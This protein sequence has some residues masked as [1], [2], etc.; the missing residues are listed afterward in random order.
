M[1]VTK[2]FLWAVVLILVG[3]ASYFML[4]QSNST[5]EEDERNMAVKD[6]AN[7][8]RIFLAD[9][10]NNKVLLERMP[11]GHW[12]VDKKYRVRKDAVD[13]LLETLARITVKAPVSK[14]IYD[15]VLKNLAADGI[16]VEVY[17]SSS[18]KP[19]RVLYVGTANQEHSGTYMMLEGASKPFMMHIEGFY[20]FLTPRFIMKSSLWR[21]NG[22]FNYAFGEIESLEVNFVGE[23]ES[24][25]KILAQDSTEYQ[26]FDLKGTKVES[27]NKTNLYSYISLFS[28]INFEHIEDIRPQTYI[29]SVIATDPKIIYKVKDVFG[30]TKTVKTYTK[31][32]PEGTEDFDGNILEFDGDRLFILIDDETFAVAQYNTFDKIALKLRFFKGE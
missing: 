28:N 24:G 5:L 7:V 27:Y 3:A 14:S 25:F 17:S 8:T 6:T 12:Q 31:P 22:V 30:E 11:N 15:K 23:P 32:F 29:D 21:F 4:G 26:L 19:T 13:L 20:G 1:R 16:K 18:D 10:K 2:F 9:R